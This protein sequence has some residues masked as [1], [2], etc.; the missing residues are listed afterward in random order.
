[1]HTH[2]TIYER[3]FESAI[4]LILYRDLLAFLFHAICS[5]DVA[6]VREIRPKEKINRISFIF[7]WLI[8]F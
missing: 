5:L 3:V 6:F 4:N 7:E 1:M 2:S 8:W